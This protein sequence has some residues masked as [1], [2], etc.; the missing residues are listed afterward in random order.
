[1]KLL[2]DENLAPSLV[3]ALADI[4]PESLHIR[5]VGQGCMIVS[6]D[7]DFRQRSFLYGHPPRSSGSG[8]EIVPREKSQDCSAIA[9]QRSRDL[10]KQMTTLFLDS[11]DA[12]DVGKQKR[13]TPPDPPGL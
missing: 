7:A 4:F 6:K 1:M 2:F 5:E 10:A 13:S 3:E 9:L 12:E 11:A 8:S